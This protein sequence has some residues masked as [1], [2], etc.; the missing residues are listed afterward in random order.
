MELIRVYR[1]MILFLKFFW[2]SKNIEN[3]GKNFPE[4]FP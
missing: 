3:A 4:F 2:F 1:G